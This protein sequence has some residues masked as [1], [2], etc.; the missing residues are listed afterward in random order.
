MMLGA[1]TWQHNVGFEGGQIK[2]SVR[3]SQFSGVGA[4]WPEG[5]H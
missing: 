3:F 4:V 1:Q 5:L 2:I